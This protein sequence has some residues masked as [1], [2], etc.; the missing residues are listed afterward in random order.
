MRSKYWEQI[1]ENFEV[2]TVFRQDDILF[3]NWFNLTLGEVIRTMPVRQD[4]N[5]LKNKTLLVYAHNIMVIGRSRAEII[6]KTA[7]LITAAKT[8][9]QDI[10]K[11]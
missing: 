7:D 3:L 10:T 9:N 8:I 6:T 5:L 1:S 11:L 2:T 4:M